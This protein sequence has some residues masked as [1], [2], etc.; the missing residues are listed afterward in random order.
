MGGA[1][2]QM[3]VEVTSDLYLTEFSEDD[4]AKVVEVNLGCRASDS[5][6]RYK[7][8]VK[9]FLG[10]GSNEAINRYRRSLILSQFDSSNK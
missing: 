7:L 5:S 9:S 8:F 6:H 1:S 2:M 3:A 4:K 10:Y